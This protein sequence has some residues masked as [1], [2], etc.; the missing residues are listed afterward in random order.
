MF[1]SDDPDAV[2][3]EALRG[4]EKL[5]DYIG[6]LFTDTDELDPQTV[7]TLREFREHVDG[8]ID[9]LKAQLAA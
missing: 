1:T 7:R 3:K 2:V 5:T 9:Q 6:D 4:E 8:C